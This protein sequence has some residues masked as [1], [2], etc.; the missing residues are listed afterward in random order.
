MLFRSCLIAFVQLQSFFEQDLSVNDVI[1][2]S[3]DTSLKV[4]VSSIINSTTIVV[5][6]AIGDGSSNQTFNFIGS[7]RID[8]ERNR[9]T[10]TLN[11]PYQGS[12]NFLKVND[13]TLSTGFLLLE[14]GVGL[15]NVEY[16]ATT[17]TEGKFQYEDLSTFSGQTSKFITII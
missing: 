8:F 15:L 1:S 12:N 7:R 17:S 10:L 9:T 3:S 11:R 2:L 13:T 5:N 14:D 4:Q 6:T 16:Q